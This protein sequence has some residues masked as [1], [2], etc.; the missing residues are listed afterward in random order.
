HLRHTHSFPTRRS[1][2]L[3]YLNGHSDMV[4]GMLVVNADDLAEQIGFIQNASG[5]VPGPFD[6]WLALRGTKTL[7]LRMRQH[8]ANGR[9]IA[10][11]LAQHPKVERVYYPGLPRTRSTRPPAAR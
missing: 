3:K 7:A 2:D 5:A 10:D 6:C 1:S 8:D 4:G 11:W 9:R